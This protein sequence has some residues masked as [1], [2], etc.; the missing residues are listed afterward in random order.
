MI[1]LKLSMARQID[2]DRGFVALAGVLITG[3]IAV[4]V[5]S[6]VLFGAS[7]FSA[8]ALSGQRS[9]QARALAEACANEA[10]LAIHD[11]TG[12]S[13]SG[14]FSLGQGTCVYTVSITGLSSREIQ[15]SGTVGTVVKRLEISIDDLS[16]TIN[17]SEWQEVA[18]F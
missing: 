14:G 4:A 13:G 5:A 8:L 9:Y 17:V 12:F 1:I 16:P 2:H 10:L 7:E 18:D 15:V 6:S 11:D 3:A